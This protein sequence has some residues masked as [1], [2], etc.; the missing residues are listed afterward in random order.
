[1][2]QVV[3]ISFLLF[4]YKFTLECR[5]IDNHTPDYNWKEKQLFAEMKQF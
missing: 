2:E 4:N 5:Y 3:N 1:M